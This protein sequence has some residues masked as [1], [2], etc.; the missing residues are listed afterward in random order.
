LCC[1]Y[2]EAGKVLLAEEVLAE[3]DFWTATV[4]GKIFCSGTGPDT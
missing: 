3:K 1:R 4:F 2:V